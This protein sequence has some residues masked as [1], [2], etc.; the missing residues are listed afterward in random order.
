M[1]NGDTGRPPQKGTTYTTADKPRAHRVR[2]IIHSFR[3]E[4][5]MGSFMEHDKKKR[6]DDRP[7]PKGLVILFCNIIL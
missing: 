5:T 1:V 2:P 7:N 6:M 3:R 4:K